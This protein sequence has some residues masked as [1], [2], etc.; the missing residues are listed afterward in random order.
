MVMIVNSDS[1]IVDVCTRVLVVVA[2]SYKYKLL[3]LLMNCFKR[4]LK[5]ILPKGSSHF[6]DSSYF[7]S[8]RLDHS[9]RY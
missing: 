1:V 2:S 8:I 7:S 3:V 6:E 9:N 4:F 5:L